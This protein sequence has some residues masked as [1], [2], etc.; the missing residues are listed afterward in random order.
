MKHDKEYLAGICIIIVIS[1]T[2]ETLV[3]HFP[4]WFAFIYNPLFLLL[5]YVLEMYVLKRGWR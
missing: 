2:L 4:L 5:I 1:S 3:L